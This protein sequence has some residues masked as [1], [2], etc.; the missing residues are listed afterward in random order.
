MEKVLTNSEMRAADGFTIKSLNVPSQTLM[1][2]AGEAIAE[3]AI[4]AAER[5][6]AKSILVVC[7]TG[8][9]GGDGYV[10]AQKLKSS[11]F[12]VKVYAAEG[13][14]S[15]DCAGA[16]EKYTGNY[17]K[18]I[19]GDVIVDC[20]FGTGLTREVDGDF[21]EVVAKI[22]G[23]GAFVISAD[24]S[25]GLCGDSGKVLG[26]AVKADLTVAIAEY[27]AGHFLGD[28]MDYCGTLIKK[29][30]GIT[31]PDD[32]YAKIYEDTD[33]NPFYPKRKR[34][35]NK[36]TYG[37]ANLISGS[38]KYV[39]AAALSAEAALKSGC[40]YVRLSSCNAV[41]NALA[42][43]LP[44]VIFIEEA[45]FTANSIAIGMGCGVSSELY[46]TIENLLKNYNGTLII[47][48]DGLNTI[49]K[50]GIDILIN[51]KCRV[52][53]TPHPK[54]FS[55]LTGISVDKI[56]SDPLNVAK[57]FAKKYGVILLLKGAA[58]IITDGK[59]T[60]INTKG[61]TA[62]S[63]AGSGDMLS[64]YM[65]GCIAR[66]LDPFDGAVCAAY[67]IGVAAEEVSEQKT[68]YCATAKDIIKNIH[69]AVLR[70]TR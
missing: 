13:K 44:Q 19:C 63:K 70:L 38:G 12:A 6:G 51:K 64:G 37:S 17:A 25:S 60:V 54:E 58:S 18:E 30:I 67:T 49:S 22:N 20:L 62:L 16:K 48:A 68:D 9:N 56:L 43:K 36:G 10:C 42:A 15:Q 32:G 55:R 57:D 59:K 3:E 29:D 28:S 52:I 47:D 61:S 26:C 31:C 1:A 24:I 21:A 4:K 27:K 53:L 14:Y 34:N 40:G 35:T 45:D 39:G 65:C 2:R 7:G 5:I 23:S 66:G 33:V 8:N 50:F 41:K 46:N 11:G 69:L